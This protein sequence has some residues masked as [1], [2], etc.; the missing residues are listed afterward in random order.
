[1]SINL[2]KSIVSS[3]SALSNYVVIVLNFIKIEELYS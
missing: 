2:T 1:M 3:Y